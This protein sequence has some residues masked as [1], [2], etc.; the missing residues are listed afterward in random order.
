MTDDE[1]LRAMQSVGFAAFVTHLDVFR[2]GQTS[3][4][5]VTALKDRT[6]WKESGCR[7]RENRARAILTAGRLRD[8]L[9]MIAASD[10]MDEIVRAAARA[11]RT[12]P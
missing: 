5:A 1:L 6:G 10:R 11:A 3:A 12:N 2:S 4:T 7:T 9:D 8:A